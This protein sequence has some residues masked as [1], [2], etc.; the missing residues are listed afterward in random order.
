MSFFLKMKTVASRVMIAIIIGSR[1]YLLL[2]QYG[3]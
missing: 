1:W 2:T 3:E